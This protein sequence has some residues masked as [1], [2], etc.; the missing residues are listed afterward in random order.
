MLH[1]DSY[2]T[3]V[4]PEI[5]GEGQGFALLWRSMKLFTALTAM[6][7]PFGLGVSEKVLELLALLCF[8]LFLYLT[9]SREGM[10]KN[11]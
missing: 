6:F 10:I 11:V 2:H 4:F 7:F 9:K 3:L 8:V 1:G 5:I